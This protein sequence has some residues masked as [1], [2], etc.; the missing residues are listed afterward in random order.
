MDMS[1]NQQAGSIEELSRVYSGERNKKV[2]AKWE[3]ISDDFRKYTDKASR[4]PHYLFNFESVTRYIPLITHRRC[5]N[6]KT[7]TT[8]FLHS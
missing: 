2:V 4:S 7:K 3:Q 1:M 8:T 6:F 5:T